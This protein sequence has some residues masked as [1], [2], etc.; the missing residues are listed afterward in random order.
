MDK[1]MTIE[2]EALASWLENTAGAVSANLEGG[3]TVTAEEIR[4]EIRLR[5]GL[6]MIETFGEGLVTFSDGSRFVGKGGAR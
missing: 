2:L 4:I 3:A 1:L 6:E 5:R